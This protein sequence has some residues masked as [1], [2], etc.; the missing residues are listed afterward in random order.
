M[1]AMT[2]H[3]F[4]GGDGAEGVGRPV[5]VSNHLP[6]L[7]IRCPRVAGSRWHTHCLIHSA[8]RRWVKQ[9]GGTEVLGQQSR[10]APAQMAAR[11][12]GGS[13]GPPLTLGLRK[14]PSAQPQ[15]PPGLVKSLHPPWLCHTQGLH[16]RLTALPQGEDL[17]S[18]SLV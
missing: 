11:A 9:V 3:G 15:V 4:W 18:R 6:S 5:K 2:W 16:E 13:R 17:D 7:S 12:L 8:T 14:E 1:L 10:P